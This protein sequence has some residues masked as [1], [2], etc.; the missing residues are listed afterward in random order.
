MR[1]DENIPARFFPSFFEALNPQPSLKR[2]ARA[3][4][5]HK[6]SHSNL[7][8]P[9]QSL[10]PLQRSIGDRLSAHRLGTGRLHRGAAWLRHRLRLWDCAPR[11]AQSGHTGR[12]APGHA[13]REPRAQGHAP[14]WQT[15]RKQ[16][17]DIFVFLL[18]AGGEPGEKGGCGSCFAGISQLHVPPHMR[19]MTCFTY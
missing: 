6:Q 8:L 18:G 10:H 9:H 15:D 7:F 17:S 11:T 19:R 1:S 2:D 16:T 4:K 14:P 12:D 5:F 3:V 13:A